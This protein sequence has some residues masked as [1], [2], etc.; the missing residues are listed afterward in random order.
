M[1]S[2]EWKLGIRFRWHGEQ[3]ATSR[4]WRAAVWRVT[5]VLASDTLCQTRSV[6]RISGECPSSTI[7]SLATIVDSRMSVSQ[8]LI[9]GDW[10]DAVDG[11]TRDLV[12]PANERV[13]GAMPSGGAADVRMA[14][15]AASKAFGSW[16]AAGPY[17][18]ADILHRAA[19]LIGERANEYAQLTT[20]E[21][22]KPI[23]EARAEWGSAVNYL[24][25]AAEEAKRICG[26]IIPSRLAGRRIDVTHE[27]LGVVGVIAAW[28]FPIYNV[29]RAVSSALAAGC[30]VVVRPSEYTP[31]SAFA[32]AE[33]LVDAGVPRGVVNVVSGAAHEMAQEMLDDVRVRKIQFTGSTRVGKILMDGASRTITRL[34]LELGGNAPV[35][36]LPDVPNLEDIAIEGVRA[37]Y[38]NAGQACIAPQRFIV[39]ESLADEFVD[40]ATRATKALSVGDPSDER[41]DIGPL[42]NARQ[43]DQIEE[44]VNATADAGARVSTGGRRMAG[45]GFFFEPTVL[46]GDLGATPSMTEEIFGPVLPITSYSS[47]ADAVSLSNDTEHGLSAYVWTSDLDTAMDI[48]ERLEFGMIGVNDWYPVTAEAPFGGVKGSGL[49]RESGTEGIMEYLETKTRYFRSLGK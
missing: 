6:N 30:T 41:T 21:S 27:S 42:V 20:E 2:S 49:G 5:D 35:L 17:V 12:N 29:N 32:Y 13:I 46:S 48:S 16:R 4:V 45:T 40:A 37:K 22:G 36:V 28:N 7:D 39:H 14:V 1:Y 43:R 34:S 24:T 11:A 9:N 15:D 19:Q 47:L 18:R 8:Q 33:A 23:S 25:Y 26:R 44:I 10:V 3:P 31:R 38:R